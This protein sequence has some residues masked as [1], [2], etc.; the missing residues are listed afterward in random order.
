MKLKEVV[1]TQWLDETE[2]TTK[3]HSNVWELSQN[4]LYIL[5]IFN[6]TELLYYYGTN[7]ALGLVVQLTLNDTLVCKTEYGI[8]AQ[9][10]KQTAGHLN[11]AYINPNMFLFLAH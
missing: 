8:A 9:I 3:Y 10:W 5:P 7:L 1:K 4:F 6:D 11:D 2:W